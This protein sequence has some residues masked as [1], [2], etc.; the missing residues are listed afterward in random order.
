MSE[1]PKKIS[2]RDFLKTAALVAGAFTLTRCAKPP[3]VQAA[4]LSKVEASANSFFKM[5]PTEKAT[6]TPFSTATD[7]PIL[8]PTSE[9]TPEIQ[10]PV[11]PLEEFELISPFLEWRL[12]GG[13]V[14]YHLGLDI[15]APENKRDIVASCKGTFVWA[16]KVERESND[17]LGN[18]VIIKY[19]WENEPIYAVYAHLE[20]VIEGKK[21]GDEISLGEVIGKMGQTGSDNVHLHLQLWNKKGWEEIVVGIKNQRLEREGWAHVAGTYPHWDN[22]EVVKKYLCDPYIWLTNITGIDLSGNV[23]P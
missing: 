15:I 7:S 5:A 12:A 19:E 2:R 4:N 1:R 22:K 21:E 14:A 8:S 16:G 6:V 18:V 20:K 17:N 11:L 13:E 23:Y 9:K 10:E 3:V